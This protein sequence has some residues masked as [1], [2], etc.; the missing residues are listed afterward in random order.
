MLKTE[1]ELLLMLIFVQKNVDNFKPLPIFIFSRSLPLR[2]N[3]V[4]EP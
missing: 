3:I 4:K 1:E 2:D